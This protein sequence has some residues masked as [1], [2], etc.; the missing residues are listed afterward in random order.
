L[1][2]NMASI[3]FAVNDVF[4]ENTGYTSTI[5]GN[6][7]T[8][9]NVNRLGRYYL[10]SFI[11]RFRKNTGNMRNGPDGMPFHG[12]PPGGGGPGGPGPGGPPM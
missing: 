3:R 12:P 4:N 9:S 2:N 11:Y 1:K 5:N 7:I 10:V 6:Y 8:Q